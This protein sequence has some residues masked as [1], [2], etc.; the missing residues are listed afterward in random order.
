MF[1]FVGKWGGVGVGNGI[2]PGRAAGCSDGAS[3]AVHLLPVPPPSRG[4]CRCGTR[5]NGGCEVGRPATLQEERNA[6]PLLTDPAAQVKPR[7]YKAAQ[8]DSAPT[9]ALSC[10]VEFR[11]FSASQG[12][13]PPPSRLAVWFDSVQ[14]TPNPCV[15]R[16]VGPQVALCAWSDL[17]VPHLFRL[18]GKARSSRGDRTTHLAH[19]DAHANPH[20]SP[21]ATRRW[22]R[23]GRG[24]LRV[25]AA[26]GRRRCHSGCFRQLARSRRSVIGLKDRCS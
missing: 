22:T 25:H 24:M 15:R 3:P 23:T 2:I 14:S 16:V 5:S 4:G 17:P 10:G 18:G 7:P 21:A 12:F 19:L 13:T 11:W 1:A 20:V 6:V 8:R 9:E 26:A